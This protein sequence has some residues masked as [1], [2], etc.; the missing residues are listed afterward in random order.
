MPGLSENFVAIRDAV[1]AAGPPPADS[2]LGDRS[3]APGA[4]L[5]EAAIR[6]LV[7]A[8][9]AD[10]L[11]AAFDEEGW[12]VPARLADETVASLTARLH[13]VLGTPP[14][15]K[16]LQVLGRLAAVLKRFDDETLLEAPTSSLRDTLRTVRGL[17]PGAVDAMLL[18]A[19]QRPVF[20][21]TTGRYRIL[22]RHGWVD[23]WATYDEASDT[24]AS[25][26]PAWADE[27]ERPFALVALGGGLDQIAARFCKAARP[28]CARCPLEPFLPPGGPILGDSDGSIDC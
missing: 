18:Q 2:L 25:A 19:L 6:R 21:I 15:P 26:L 4:R 11:V 23:P 22:V 28:E 20:P 5:V 16:V 3:R 27:A 10:R 24:V 1:E 12:L 13:D 17:G 7:T 9:V 8:K 14:N